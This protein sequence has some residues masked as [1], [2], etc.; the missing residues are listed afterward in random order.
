MAVVLALAL[1]VTAAAA[2]VPKGGEGRHVGTEGDDGRLDAAEQG[3][4]HALHLVHVPARVAAALQ[5][6][7]AHRLPQTHACDG[8]AD[9][10]EREEQH[11]ADCLFG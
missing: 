8:S 10:A 5:L 7:H 9:G 3:Q 11:E 2:C 6:R 1:A 4:R